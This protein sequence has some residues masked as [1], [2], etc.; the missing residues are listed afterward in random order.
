M[1][2][3]F[4]LHMTRNLV[5]GILISGLLRLHAGTETDVIPE[6][7]VYTELQISVPFEE[8]PWQEIS[9]KLKQVPGLLSKTWLSGTNGSVGGFYVFDTIEH[10]KTFVATIFPKEAAAFGVAQTTRIFD[11]RETENA[12]RDMRSIMYTGQKISKPGAFVYT[13]LQVYRL[14]FDETV[15][16]KARNPVLMREEGLLNKTWLSGLHTGTIGGF[17]AFDTMENAK[18]FTIQE[19]P[20]VAESLNT[21]FYT[22]IFDAQATREAST[23]M[24]SAFYQK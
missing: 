12:S 14:P 15:P 11:A 8:V 21:A 6:A 4:W 1:K 13:E 3:T 10:A 23:M 18:R 24:N 2:S 5:L 22:R 7:F 16:W 19:L 9:I 20:K 17:Y